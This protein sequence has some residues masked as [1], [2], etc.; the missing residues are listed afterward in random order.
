M[1]GNLLEIIVYLSIIVFPEIF[2]FS[3][4]VHS[5]I[6]HVFVLLCTRS[7]QYMSVKIFCADGA[8]CN[9]IELDR[10]MCYVNVLGTIYYASHATPGATPYF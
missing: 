6:F 10:M 5:N 7:S 1:F 8:F 3:V 4:V 2:A 9:I